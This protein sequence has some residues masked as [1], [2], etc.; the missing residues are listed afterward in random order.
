M[1]RWKD[2]EKTKYSTKRVLKDEKMMKWWK[3]DDK[4]LNIDN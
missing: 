3:D 2:D 4:Q 1:K